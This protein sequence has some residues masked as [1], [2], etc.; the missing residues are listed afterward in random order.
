MYNWSTDEV[1]LKKNYQE[2]YQ[3]WRTLQLINYGLDGEKLKFEEIKTLWS[4]IK[5][6]ITSNSKKKYLASLLDIND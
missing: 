6:K 3:L 4:E 5:D 2:K 1:A